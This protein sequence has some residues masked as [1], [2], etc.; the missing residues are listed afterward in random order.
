MPAARP[1]AT[2]ATWWRAAAWLMNMA[3]LRLTWTTSSNAASLTSA[4]RSS[5]WMPTQLTSRSRLPKRPATPSMAARMLSVE[6]ASMAT[7]IASWPAARSAPASASALASLRPATA[8]RAPASASPQA[9]AA[10]MPP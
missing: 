8:T 7:P 6:C 1:A 2:A 3:A 5:R 9:I 4:W 10:P